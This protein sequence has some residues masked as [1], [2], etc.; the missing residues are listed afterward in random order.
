MLK[1]MTGFGRAEKQ[2][3]DYSCRV[4]VRS[5]NN[6]FLEVNARLPKYLSQ[7][8]IPLKKL[9]KGNFARGSFDISVVLEKT[10]GTVAE[11]EAIPNIPLASQYLQALTQLRD[12]LGLDEEIDFKSILGLR[13]LIKFEPPKLNEKEER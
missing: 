5:V 10:E 3:G 1:S 12:G 8:E 11:M 2:N 6:R 13:D 4:E 7:L 9:I